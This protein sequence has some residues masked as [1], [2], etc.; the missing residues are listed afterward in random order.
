M[1]ASCEPAEMPTESL[2]DPTLVFLRTVWALDHGLQSHSKKME[3]SNGVTGPQRLILRILELAPGTAPS[4]L[5][6]IL[7]FHKSTVTVILRSLEK[8]KLVRRAPNVT[9]RRAIVLTL[10]ASGRK[11]AEQRAGTVE[12]VV[13][14][15]LAKMPLREVQIAQRVLHELALAFA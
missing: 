7:C 13:G 5:A 1:L 12:A 11:I 15:T 14:K 9:D 2:S 4:E 3:A 6:R 10:T 8:A